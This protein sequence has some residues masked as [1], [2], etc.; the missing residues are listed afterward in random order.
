MGGCSRP[1]DNPD[2]RIRLAFKSFYKSFSRS[3]E[4]VAFVNGNHA[5]NSAEEIFPAYRNRFAEPLGAEFLYRRD[6]MVRGEEEDWFGA[7]H[8][9]TATA[10]RAV[11]TAR[12]D[13]RGTDKTAI[14]QVLAE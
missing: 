13:M 4:T 11:R 10:A 6:R 3:V 12:I 2:L 7:G 9:A 5:I 1:N 8:L 14:F